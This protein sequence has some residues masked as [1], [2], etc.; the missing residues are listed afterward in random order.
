KLTVLDHFRLGLH[1]AAGDASHV[2]KHALADFIDGLGAVDHSTGRQVQI[3]GHPLEYRSIGSQLNHRH[4]GVTHR[5]STARCEYND[6]GAGPDGTWRGLLVVAGPLHQVDAPMPRLL[7]VLDDAFNP[8]RAC[9]GDRAKRFDRYVQQPASD[10][11]RARIFRNSR[12][13]FFRI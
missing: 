9:F 1:F 10:I 5:A 13:K 12:A 7:A 3:A 2:L 11:A 4:D 8:R 6:W